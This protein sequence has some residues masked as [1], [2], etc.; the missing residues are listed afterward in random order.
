M[1]RDKILKIVEAALDRLVDEHLTLLDLDV[2]E[3]ALSHHLALYISQLVPPDYNVDV[4]Y[5]RHNADPKRLNLPPRMALDRE[6]R[7]T[8]VFPDIIVH[9]RGTDENNLLVLEMKKPGEAMTYDERKLCAFRRELG[10]EHAAHI[11]IGKDNGSI[12][13]NVIWV[14]G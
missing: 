10:Y 7:A 3:R 11:V 2:T 6:L 4:E 14:D 8:T 9:K 12:V 5:N 13:R 1:E